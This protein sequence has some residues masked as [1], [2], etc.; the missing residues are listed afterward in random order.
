[1]RESLP[2][3]NSVIDRIPCVIH[4]SFRK[5]LYEISSAAATINATE[6]A[7]VIAPHDCTAAGE[8]NGFVLLDGEK[9]KDP[10]QIEAEYLQKVLGLKALGGFS[11]WVNPGGYIGK[12]A[13]YEY[14]I[15][16][17]SG[18]PTFFT[19]A[20]DDVPFYVDPESIQ[21]P[22]Q[23]AEQLQLNRDALLQPISNSEPLGEVWKRLPFPVASVAVGGI[24][25][26]RKRLLLIE[27]GR[28]KSGQLTIPGTTVRARE[29]RRD[30]LHRAINEKFG[31]TVSEIMP[32][33]TGFMIDDSGYKKP[34]DS[35][36]F[37]DRLITTSSERVRPQDGLSH[38]WVSPK[39]TKAL[40]DSNRIEPNAASLLNEYFA[41]SA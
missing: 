3:Q 20:P 41:G 33:K 9:D 5:H 25:H 6:Q 32:L 40:L 15:A 24:V 17:A 16:Q 10:R 12:S 7:V 14:G 28:W 21:R 13:A 26:Y 4:G 38:H 23:L 18:V 30:A 31:M 22:E 8:K 35:L 11:L 19:E 27:D 36:V 1:M 2:E 29:T 37:D 39:E 34:I